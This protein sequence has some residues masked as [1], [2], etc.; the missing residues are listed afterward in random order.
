MSDDNYSDKE[1]AF[2]SATLSAWYTTKF[3]K[4]K[5]LLSL[6][7]AAIGLLVTLATAIG[8]STLCVAAMYALAVFSFLICVMAV[9]AIFDRNSQ[10]LEN[11][12][13]NVNDR[14]PLLSFLDKLASS[15]F[16]FGIIFTLLVGLLSGI[17]SYKKEEHIMAENKEKMVTTNQD[18]LKKSLDG[19]AAMRPS[20]PPAD[21]PNNQSEG[22]SEKEKKQP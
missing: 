14:D 3:E 22:S 5:H 16:I 11:L 17:E 8:T 4:D 9:L 13:K 15:S 19:A 12:V 18:T 7:S 20:K 6:S 10:Y 21:N 1:V 2:Y